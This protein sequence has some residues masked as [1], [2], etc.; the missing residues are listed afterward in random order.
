MDTVNFFPVSRAI[1][2]DILLDSSS[3]L[4]IS[5]VHFRQSFSLEPRKSNLLVTF[6]SVRLKE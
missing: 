4:C 1:L 5:P 2:T 6:L 3:T